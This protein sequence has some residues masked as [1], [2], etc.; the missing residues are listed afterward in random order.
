MGTLVVAT[1]LTATTHGASAATA[2]KLVNLPY[3]VASG[4]Y[5]AVGGGHDAHSYWIWYHDARNAADKDY[6]V[7]IA[8]PDG[9]PKSFTF[10]LPARAKP[11]IDGSDHNKVV[12][13]GPSLSTSDRDT[14]RAGI[15]PETRSAF[16]QLAASDSYAHVD[17]RTLTTAGLSVNIVASTVGSLVGGLDYGLSWGPGLRNVWGQTPLP[18]RGTLECRQYGN[19]A[20]VFF[21]IPH[22]IRFT[23][24]ED[25]KTV[26]ANHALAHDP[27]Q[28]ATA[29]FALY[30]P[31]SVKTFTV[32]GGSPINLFDC[33]NAD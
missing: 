18:L 28:P 19:Q 9:L 15:L 3:N 32:N 22:A 24:T 2:P 23:L 11:H 5:Q 8:V 29:A 25:G 10:A 31:Q 13:V 7:V 6:A 20:L 17:Q 1:S 30:M 26:V 12:I 14:L 16:F 27:I 4:S 33:E 21:E